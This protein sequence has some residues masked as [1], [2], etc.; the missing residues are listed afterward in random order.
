[1]T[2]TYDPTMPTDITR[3]R[4]HIGDVDSDEAIFSD[5]EI[6][7]VIAEESTWQNAV[8]ACLQSL[9]GRMSAEPDFTADW[10]KVDNKRAL[11]GYKELLQQKRQQFG[12]PAVSGRGQAVYRGDSLQ[13]GPGEGW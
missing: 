8:I 11:A 2:F 1:M 6:T 3:V 13:T 10:L 5:E 4:F 12:I 9:I 7:F